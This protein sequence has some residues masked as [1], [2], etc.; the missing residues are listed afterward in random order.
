MGTFKL[1]I[2]KVY[3]HDSNVVEGMGP[4]PISHEHLLQILERE[5]DRIKWSAP[6]EVII[7]KGRSG[8]LGI[9]LNSFK[10]ETDWYTVVTKVK[11]DCCIRRGLLN[12]F[13]RIVSIDNESI[14]HITGKCVLRKLQNLPESNIVLT[15][16]YVDSIHYDRPAL[17]HVD[18]FTDKQ[19]H[20]SNSFEQLRSPSQNSETI[21]TASAG[22]LSRNNTKASITQD[23]SLTLLSC[24]L[25]EQE[26][27]LKRNPKCGIENETTFTES[28]N[29]D[30]RLSNESESSVTWLSDLE[31]KNGSRIIKRGHSQ[32]S[33]SSSNQSVNS[34]FPLLKK[35]GMRRS[36]ENKSVRPLF[37]P[38]STDSPDR[39]EL[40]PLNLRATDALSPVPHGKSEK[41]N[42]SPQLHISK[43]SAVSMQDIMFEE[44]GLVPTHAGHLSQCQCPSC[45]GTSESRVCYSCGTRPGSSPKKTTSPGVSLFIDSQEPLPE[46]YGNFLLKN[47]HLAVWDGRNT[48]VVEIDKG[49]AKEFGFS[50][51][52]KIGKN[53]DTSVEVYT[54]VKS[55]D[56]GG[57]AMGKLHLGDW[58]RSVNGT[59]IQKAQEAFGLITSGS[60]SSTMRLV[61]QRPVGFSQHPNSVSSDK[62]ETYLQVARS[63][64]P[65][66]NTPSPERKE[67]DPLI[68]GI[69]E[70]KKDPVKMVRQQNIYFSDMSLSNSETDS[71]I[72]PFPRTVKFPKVRIFVCGSEAEKYV[73]LLLKESEV[74][75]IFQNIG[76]THVEFSMATNCFGNVV[77]SK[78][79]SDLYDASNR[80]NSYLSNVNQSD[81]RG[82]GD[83]NCKQCGNDFSC[84]MSSSAIGTIVNVDLFVVPDDK[85]FYC[86]CPYLFTKSSLFILTFDGDKM[87]RAAP[88][89]F[90]R[91]W[92]LSHTIR[93]FAGEECHIMSCGLLESGA[94]AN[95]ML[96]EV[97]ALFYTPFNTRL[98]NYNVSGPELLNL[99]SSQSASNITHLSHTHQS[100]LW[101]TVTDTIQR[102]HVLQPSLLVVDYLHVLRDKE[103][104]LTEEQFMSVIK[105]RLP[106]YKLDV[107]Q[108]ILTYLNTFGEIMLGKATPYFSQG[109]HSIES[110]VILN[111]KFLLGSLN[112]VLSVIYEDKQTWS[113]TLCTGFLRKSDLA[114]LTGFSDVMCR[115]VIDFWECNGLIFRK[116]QSSEMGETEFFIP[117][118]SQVPSSNEIPLAGRK[119]LEL[120][121]Q[122]TE[123]E[124][125]QSFYQ[126]VFT[127]AAHSDNIDSLTVPGTNCAVFTYKGF[128]VTAFHQKIEDRIKFILCREDKSLGTK[129]AELFSWLY[130]TCHRYLET[131][132]TL[133]SLCPLGEAC[134]RSPAVG[135]HL[136]DLRDSKPQYCGSDR[137][138]TLNP[139]RIWRQKDTEHVTPESVSSQ[140]T[141]KPVKQPVTVMELP[142]SVF[143]K[144]CLKLKVTSP[145]GRDWK[146]L[147]GQM[148]YSVEQVDVYETAKEPVQA[149]LCDWGR[150]T[151]A[152][153]EKLLSLLSEL[154]RE[155]I[156]SDI[157]QALQQSPSLV[158][159]ST[160]QSSPVDTP[161]A[162][163]SPISNITVSERGVAY[164]GRENEM[165]SHVIPKGNITVAERSVANVGIEDGVGHSASLSVKLNNLDN[166]N[167]VDV[168]TGIGTE[169]M[170]TPVE[171][172]RRTGPLQQS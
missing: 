135:T 62:S 52:V 157:Q 94:E 102:Q 72:A 28:E 132:F 130:G 156:I 143:H 100:L 17:K 122:F 158:S 129:P 23:I 29:N 104:L 6:R 144:L 41:F 61:I 111:P 34:D 33:G 169:M 87:L 49:Q 35:E 66:Q 51:K 84:D 36:K 151:N 116:P 22:R 128:L 133:C 5:P 8:K 103:M 166:N 54:L 55:V 153:I 114:H 16:T 80:L 75:T 109:V 56:K 73:D 108:M 101:K 67:Q 113:R 152:T 115:N 31:V 139:I 86:C 60:G 50:F 45:A 14:V 90:S 140:R 44:Q 125:S 120:Y 65:S 155:D 58:I 172:P 164:D 126:V 26:R 59:P 37:K 93:S 105:S 89:E 81:L 142:W 13:D 148:G 162:D 150:S 117:Y 99:Q 27:V 71:G 168:V 131:P 18:I 149:L 32:V 3:P 107:H 118:F 79:C 106:D 121:L 110:R 12:V 7:C 15:V 170:I 98:Q 10:G 97:R 137:I 30:N 124:S 88:Q 167:K 63:P 2:S 91:L 147:A 64:S 83:V 74:E 171:T 85:L 21:S 154:D 20:C 42:L 145:L 78:I 53:Q 82:G 136:I 123:H 160:C 165:V 95:N 96:D 112:Y 4:T 163:L 70:P 48:H 68:P 25:S 161:N 138:D 47:P 76:Y 69:I 24:E 46:D 92:S 39:A 77:T 43:D 11:D 19:E 40:E 57:P 9:K 134:H 159:R 1:G 119:D 38:G 141:S 146:G 127:L